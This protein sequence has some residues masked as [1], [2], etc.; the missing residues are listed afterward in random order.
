ML[1]RGDYYTHADLWFCD[2]QILGIPVLRVAGV[3]ADDVIGTVAKR[4]IEDGFLVAIASPDKVIISPMVHA[5]ALQ[6]PHN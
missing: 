4:A 3:E 1:T 2:R 5:C 6:P